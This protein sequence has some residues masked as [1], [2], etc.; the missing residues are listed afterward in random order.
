MASFSNHDTRRALTQLKRPLAWTRAG[1]IAETFVRSLWPLI[2][3]VLLVL[4][5][6][7][8]GLHETLP[9]EAIWGLGALTGLA[10][11]WSLYY[12]ART[13]DWPSRAEAEVRLD[14]TLAGRPIQ[15]LTDVQAI[16]DGDAA[17]AEVW[18]AHKARMA[19]QAAQASAVAPDLRVS[20]RDPF[21]L[22]YVAVLAF[23]VALLFGSF[24]RLGSVGELAAGT[25]DLGGG[26]VWEG[27]I[28]PPVY[29]GKPRFI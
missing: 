11:L 8:L 28:A 25:A 16:G 12:A 15:A 20:K 27:W 13:W 10:G 7:M 1:M 19:E 2:T 22:R 24:W 23:L 26:P 5:A 17:S 6:L 3:V 4:A 14:A 9:L 21:A 29:T 18:R